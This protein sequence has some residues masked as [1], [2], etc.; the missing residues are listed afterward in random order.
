LAL[1]YKIF[2]IKHKSELVK[3]TL[4]WQSGSANILFSIERVPKHICLPKEEKGREGLRY[5]F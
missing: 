4:F 3:K 2:K 5:E 1:I